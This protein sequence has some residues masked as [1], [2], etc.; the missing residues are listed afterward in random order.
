MFMKPGNRKYKINIERLQEVF[1][2]Y[3][4][5]EAVYL[6]GSMATGRMHHESDLDLAILSYDQNI[7]NKK[8]D[9]LEDLVQYD[10]CDVDIIFIDESD[11]V[12]AYEA[13]RLN[14]VIYCRDD[15]DKGEIYSKIIRKYLDL[16]PY[17]K[18]QRLAYKK[19][20]LNG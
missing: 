13:V 9:I 19:R 5:I 10:F 11:T 14:N 17:L 16:Y 1:Q 12:M 3:Q 2:K 20:V 4:E 18:V 7:R 6:F 15:F 8:L